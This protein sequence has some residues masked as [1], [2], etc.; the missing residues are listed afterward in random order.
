MLCCALLLTLA[1]PVLAL[2]AGWGR[3]GVGRWATGAGPAAVPCCAGERRWCTAPRLWSGLGVVF[4]V[5][6]VAVALMHLTHLAA[7]VTSDLCT[8]SERTLPIR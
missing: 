1:S 4:V 7:P 5:V 3:A 6:A 8:S 2:W